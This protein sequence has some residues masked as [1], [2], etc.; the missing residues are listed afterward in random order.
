[1]GTIA[2]TITNREILGRSVL[3]AGTFAHVGTYATNGDLFT[4]A[5]LGLEKLDTMIVSGDGGYVP[6]VDLTNKKILEF[7]AGA[8]AAP[9]DEVTNATD[10]TT[11]VA[12]AHFTCFGRGMAAG[13]A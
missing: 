10:L 1:M 12:V 11:A 7:E 5:A 2:F 9:L 13:V 8:D 6:Q 4:L 3:I